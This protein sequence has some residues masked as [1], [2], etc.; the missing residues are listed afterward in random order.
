MN[1]HLECVPSLASLTTRRFA[2][3]DLERLG[4]KPDGAL[5]AEVLGFGSL[6]KLLADLLQALY[7]AA[8]QGDT[9]FVYFLQ[10][11]SLAS[12]L[13]ST[14]H[15][16][17][18]THRPITIVAFFWLLVRHIGLLERQIWNRRCKSRQMPIT[19]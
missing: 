19:T 12:C 17:L 6:D 18:E 4:W 10:L 5:D 7:F 9:D 3:R 2:G 13:R 11:T 16:A 8:C 14:V 1:P 15:R